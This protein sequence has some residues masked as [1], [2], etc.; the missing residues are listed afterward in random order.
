MA[1]DRLYQREPGGVWYFWGYDAKGNRYRVSTKQRDRKA[2]ERAARE[3]ERRRV[4]DPVESPGVPLGEA[5]L[6][7]KEVARR[8]GR[9]EVVQQIAT[10]KGNHLLKFFGPDFDLAKVTKEALEEYADHRIEEGASRHTVHKE[11]AV[12]RRA[13]RVSGLGWDTAIMPDLGR[14]Y[15]PRDRWL[16]PEEFRKLHAELG[17]QRVDSTDRR[18]HLVAYCYAGLRRSELE[19]I[20]A[21]DVDL[22]RN[23]LLVRGSKTETSWRWVPIA[24]Q[25]R[26]VLE[27]RAQEHQTGPLFEPWSNDKRDL[28]LACERAKIE[29][30]TPTDL[31]RTFCSWLANSGVTELVAAK[32]MGHAST[33]M[34][35]QVYA[36]LGVGIQA[37]AVARLGVYS[38]ESDAATASEQEDRS[39]A[40]KSVA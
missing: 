26:P 4:L 34:V 36:R 20:V 13:R 3:I 10:Q 11:L 35:N 8:A 37:D 6:R 24:P 23:L 40:K 18:D 9:S 16:T 31:R 27:R 39:K 2:A 22:A 38:S 30:V 12:L 29:K 33:K 32:L 15:V 21:T 1:S 7:V 25:L 5:L 19:G 28:E 17:P 14:F